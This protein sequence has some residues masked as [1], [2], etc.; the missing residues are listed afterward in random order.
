MA[1][2]SY[3]TNNPLAVKLWSKKLSVEAL[4]QTWFAKFMGSDSNS[5]IQIKDE[6]SKQA[7]DRIT[8]G[9]RM[10]LTS[11]GIQGDST[12]EGFEEALTTYSDNIFIDQLRTAVRSSGQMSEQRV[13]FSVR[14]E[15][16]SGLQDWWSDRLDY[17]M[18]NQLAG[19]TA[20]TDTRFTGNQAAIA[21]SSTNYFIAGGASG[22]LE[23]SL[24]AT[25]TQILTL[26]DIDRAVN[27][28]KTI[29]PMIRPINVDG[30][31]MYALF[32]HPNQ[33]RALRTNTNTGQ[34]L[35][36]QKAAMTGGRV[37]DNPIFT[38][39]LGIYNNVMLYEAFRIPNT[40]TANAT[41]AD[42][43]PFRRAVF[44]GAQAGLMAFGQKTGT[45]ARASWDEETFD[46][47][48]QFGVSAGMIFGTKK[49]VF[50]SRDFATI[51]IGSYAPNP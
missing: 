38:G 39:M 44:A 46:Y 50:N 11:A 37:K 28:A 23:T 22:S 31:Q 43:T 16:R 45:S 21:P 30:D 18:F 14:E 6:T 47:G 4:K 48:N 26:A 41:Q 19:N 49:T 29:S 40:V 10:Q 5:L 8:V 7:G 2:T 34:W 13:T 20:L 33:V 3:P 15:A 27:I 1:G 17:C 42:Q 25:T 51:V 32:L 35:D 24:S 9:L 12:L 36:I